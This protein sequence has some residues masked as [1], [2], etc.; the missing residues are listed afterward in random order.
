[1]PVYPMTQSTIP[2]KS[3]VPLATGIQLAIPKGHVATISS[4]ENPSP[5]EP[6]VCPGILDPAY[7][8]EL[9]LL[10]GNLTDKPLVVDPRVPI[11]FIHLLAVDDIAGLAPCGSLRDLGLP[12]P[13]IHVALPP[14]DEN[15]APSDHAEALALLEEYA[16]LFSEGPHDFGLLKGTSHHLE[17][18][19]SRPFRSQPYQKSKVEE[20][21]VAIELRQ[22]LDAGLLQPSK[23]PWA[24][25][26]LLLRKK[27]GGH[28]VVMDYR[29]LNSITKK[30]SYPL[31]RI[32]DSLRVL[33]G[34]K[35][36]SA[37][38]LASGYWQVDL[39]P[40]D[41]EKCALISSE[42]LFEPTRMPQG[43][44]NAPATFQRAMDNI[45]GDLKMSCVLVYLDDITVFSRTFHE[46]L[47]HLRLVFDR[48]RNA[49]L[50][51]KPAKCSFFQSE[52]EFL[53]HR[54]SRDGI[55]PLPGKVD[56]IRQ[57]STPA[58]L[59]DIQ[60]FIGM[61]GYYR[62]FVP[63]FAELAEPL[64]R[65]LTKDTPF[66]WGEEQ[67]SAFRALTEALATSP[68][69]VHPDFDKPFILFTD[70]S[71]VAVGAILAQHDD[72]KVD[73]PI[74]YYSKTLSKAERNYS[75]TERECLAVLLA[76]KQFRPFLYG[77]HFTVVTD[78]SSLKWL[79]QMKDPDGRLARW[80]LKLQ[81]HD[82]TIEHRAGA[83]HQNADGL[84]RLPPIAFL[85]PEDDRLFDLLGRP[86]LWHLEPAAVQA[87]LKEMST[88]T[89]IKDGLIY[90]QVNSAW[91]P[92]I[93]PSARTDAIMEGHT[94]IGHGAVR[95]TH[96]WLRSRC[97]WEGM[98]DSIQQTLESCLIC[99]SHAGPNPKFKHDIPSPD[100]PFHVVSI[101]MIGPLP[102]A[103][104]GHRYILIAVDHLT[105]WVEA[106]SAA[107]ATSKNVA[108]FLLKFLF[109]RHGSPRV[110]LSDN[111]LNFTSQPSHQTL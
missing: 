26:L 14:L 66:V 83:I 34:S 65:L 100:L 47:T 6:L 28:R 22:L 107:S 49:G 59:R 17:L 81:H 33:G 56:A 53:G 67:E 12:D 25:P 50:K 109:A 75:V 45:L 92:Y 21:Q 40:E 51:L 79:Q 72:N 69:L 18:E 60:V 102:T 98:V 4:H 105:K 37:M 110:L 31:P 44:C 10:V 8:D 32:D 68:V 23:S 57:M 70:A 85:S 11:A 84:S 30:D 3:Q 88:A 39:S 86:D 55:A 71:D 64:V 78:H 82:F 46:H 9:V 24:S 80:A 91:L 13:S 77:T 35:Y 73:H 29:R 87:R 52:M 96:E 108:T 95:K 62:Q 19:D 2:P 89:Q 74:A 103:I 76:I 15:L 54:V 63:H 38:D 42:G 101:D 99:R 5:R 27:D 61:V 16:D 90:K 104:G 106:S 94:Q 48:L 20:A 43:L 58:S 7:A 93:R 41:R 36:F 97:Y 111:G 1:M